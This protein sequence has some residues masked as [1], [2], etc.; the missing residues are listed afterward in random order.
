[1]LLFFWGAVFVSFVMLG[2]WACGFPKKKKKLK[3]EPLQ[4]GSRPDAR[5]FLAHHVHASSTP[6]LFWEMFNVSLSKL[7]Y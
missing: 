3:I 5:P 1:M 4:M 6:L 2:V 7:K